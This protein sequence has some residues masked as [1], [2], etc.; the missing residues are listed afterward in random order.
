[1]KDTLAQQVKIHDRKKMEEKMSNPEDSSFEFINEVFRDKPPTYNKS[2]Y[3]SDLKVQ[4][5]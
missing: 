3:F 1:M 4:A 5:S 2:Q